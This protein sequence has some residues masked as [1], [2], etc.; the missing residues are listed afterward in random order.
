[1][2]IVLIP[3]EARSPPCIATKMRV[4]MA[5]TVALPCCGNSVSLKRKGT[6]HDLIWGV[7]K[8]SG[9]PKWMVKIREN[10]IRID[11]LG[12]F[13]TPIFGFLLM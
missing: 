12:G 13:D 11:D 4:I 9:T 1:M 5:G 2:I 8:N 6:V 10:P 7:S 3:K